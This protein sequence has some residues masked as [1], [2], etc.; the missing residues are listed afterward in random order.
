MGVFMDPEMAR[1]LNESGGCPPGEALRRCGYGEAA[2]FS[3]LNDSLLLCA[4]SDW[5]CVEPFLAQRDVP[6]F[7]NWCLL[8]MQ[9]RAMSGLRRDYLAHAPSN[10]TAWGWKDPR[11]TLTLPYWLR[12]FPDARVLNV[13]R[14]SSAVVASLLKRDA[15]FS[16]TAEPAA[17]PGVLTR[18]RRV[19]TDPAYATR[20]VRGRLGALPAAAPATG[21]MGRPEYFELTDMYVRECAAARDLTENYLEVSYED[22]LARPYAIAHRM[23]A[24][25]GLVPE[26]HVLERAVQFVERPVSPK[27]TILPGARPRRLRTE[28]LGR[29][30][31]RNIIGLRT[32][33]R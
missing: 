6:A 5:R 26:E 7:R 23:A 11:N 8:L 29:N 27:G 3:R 2:A 15:A 30:V 4:G 17:P 14:E 10:L 16:A 32:T 25:A 18:A 33:A 1:L 13:R 21:A 12:L 24:F 9:A 19:L 20:A 31:E 28:A 22:L